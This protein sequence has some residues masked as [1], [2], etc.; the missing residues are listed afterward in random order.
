MLCACSLS[1]LPVHA[2]SCCTCSETR[3]PTG[4]TEVAQPYCCYVLVHL[5]SCLCT[6]SR[7][8]PAVRPRLPQGRPRS[9]S[10]M[11]CTNVQNPLKP[12]RLMYRTNARCC[13]VLVHSV[14]RWYILNLSGH[15]HLKISLVSKPTMYG[16]LSAVVREDPPGL[17]RCGR[18]GT[19]WDVDPIG[20]FLHWDTPGH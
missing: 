13:C 16:C 8:E 10:R 5:V 14:S 19:H 7:A 18:T 20:P 15:G 3:A 12:I 9:H 1:V 11:H 4:K 17:P 2:K 6:L